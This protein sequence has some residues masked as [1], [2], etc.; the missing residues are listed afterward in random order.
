M[1]L[2]QAPFGLR[3]GKANCDWYR[4]IPM[5]AAT[6]RGTITLDAGSCV[7]KLPPNFWESGL[8]PRHWGKIE[9]MADPF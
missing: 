5:E 6:D 3:N 9:A 8:S 1:H 2:R 4:K 7:L